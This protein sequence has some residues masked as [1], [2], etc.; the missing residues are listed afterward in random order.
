MMRGLEGIRAIEVGGVAV[1]PLAGMLLS[2]WGAEVIHVEPPGRVGG[3]ILTNGA[4]FNRYSM[5]LGYNFHSRNFNE[6]R[7]LAR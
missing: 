1:M 3:K 6:V 4:D 5:M 7:R 2:T